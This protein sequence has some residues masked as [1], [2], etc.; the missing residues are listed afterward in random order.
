MEFFNSDGSIGKILLRSIRI[1]LILYIKNIF[2]IWIT[3]YSDRYELDLSNETI[4]ISISVQSYDEKTAEN[5]RNG[6]VA[7]KHSFQTIKATNPKFK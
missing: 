4:K 1:H 7:E 5:D 6:F 2:V 3:V